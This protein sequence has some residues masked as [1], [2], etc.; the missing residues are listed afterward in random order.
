MADRGENSPRCARGKLSVVIIDLDASA[1]FF[2]TLRV[3]GENAAV[4]G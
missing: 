1:L 2:W 4:L 3:E